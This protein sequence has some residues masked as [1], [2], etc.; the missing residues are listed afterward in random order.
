[1]KKFERNGQDLVEF[2]LILPIFLFIVFVIFDLGRAVYYF[3]AIT[4]AAREG[5][6][7]GVI[8]PTEV[9]QIKATVCKF[10]VGLDSDCP[11]AP[12]IGITVNSIDE[13]NGAPPIRNEV[14][15][16]VVTYSFE[17]V[18]PGVGLLLGL[19]QGEGIEL[20]S[21]SQMRIEH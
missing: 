3:S 13:D 9:N 16:V 11:S 4:N 5:A 10:A 12:G 17:P 14:I 6:R 2:A 7:Y 1:M 8:Y 19:N 20:L 18:T 15:Q 21:Q